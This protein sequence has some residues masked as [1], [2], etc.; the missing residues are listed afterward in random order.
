MHNSQL[1]PRAIKSGSRALS[2]KARLGLGTPRSASRA[3][4]HKTRPRS[5]TSRSESCV[6]YASAEDGDEEDRIYS[7][8]SAEE[9]R[10]LYESTKDKKK[11]GLDMQ[12]LCDSLKR[13]RSGVGA[14]L[15]HINDPSHKVHEDGWGVHIFVF[16]CVHI[17]VQ[18]GG[19]LL[20]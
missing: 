3:F 5:F 8:W 6:L 20:S 9:D 19:G 14:R 11:E 4:S 12:A 13:G 16:V 15:K 10:L 18:A 7:R 17:P 1:Q 2:Y